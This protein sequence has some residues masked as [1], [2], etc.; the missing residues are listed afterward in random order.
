MN[1]ARIME[2]PL[3]L[4]L[5][6]AKKNETILDVSSPKLLALYYAMKGYGGVVAADLEDYFVSDFDIYKKHAKLNIQTA[7]FNAA[8]KIP[9]PDSHF[10]KIFSVSVI[11]H[12]PDD[13]DILAMK[14][15]LRVLKPSGSLVITLPV[16][17]HYVEEWTSSAHYWK[18][19]EK[20]GKTFYQR[21][22]DEK[23]LLKNFSI[24]GSVIQDVILI[25]E[26]P[27]ES[28]RMG[29]NGMML[30]NSYYI[31]KVPTARLLKALGGRLRRIPFVD[32]LA[33]L[34]VS[35]KCHYLTTDW[36]DPNIRQV[37]VK[38]TKTVVSE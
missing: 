32:Y 35:R 6:Q 9:Y 11:E 14:E 16:F 13:G 10:D 1:Y 12:I 15:M 17:N 36:T 24:P 22:Y 8:R 31:D 25:A 26:R 27:V 34:I 5:L 29:E 30:H 21:R 19:V 2:L 37:A 7:V 3:T 38:M 33:E 4:L 18:S 23:T 28:P 20:D